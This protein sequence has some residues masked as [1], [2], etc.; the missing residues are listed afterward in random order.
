[1]GKYTKQNM[2][3]VNT[4]LTAFSVSVF[5]SVVLPKLVDVAKDVADYIDRISTETGEDGLPLFT[6]AL[7]DTTGI[8]IYYQGSLVGVERPA[9]LYN[10]Q[11]SMPSYQQDFDPDTVFNEA[12]K[13]AG[14]TSKDGAWMVIFA[15]APYAIEV[16]TDGSY[17]KNPR[18]EGFFWDITA[19]A[20]EKLRSTFKTNA[21]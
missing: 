1:M 16:N 17:A 8:G 12:L 18:G 4:A 3:T 5:M 14:A 21:A 19:Y 9:Q 2:D 20:E 11:S 7:H 10:L 13:N 15:A 6:G